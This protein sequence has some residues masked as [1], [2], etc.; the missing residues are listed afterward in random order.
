MQ[1]I[2]EIIGAVLAVIVVWLI[3]LILM[4]TGFL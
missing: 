4:L 1:G 3:V 2:K